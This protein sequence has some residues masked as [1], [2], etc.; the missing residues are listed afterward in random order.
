M[1]ADSYDTTACVWISDTTIRI[2]NSDTGDKD[3]S[4]VEG[5][6]DT[7]IFADEPP[8]L[9]YAHHVQRYCRHLGF[10]NW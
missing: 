10:P 6:A 3:L 4:P 1:L 7:T 2:W 8:V 5:L 9:S